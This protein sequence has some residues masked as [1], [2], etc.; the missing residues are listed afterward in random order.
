MIRE[1]LQGDIDIAMQAI[2]ACGLFTSE[3][4]PFL[5]EQ[6]ERTVSGM[7]EREE[8]WLADFLDDGSARGVC[9]CVEEPLTDRVWN[10][11]F[12][13]VIPDQ[14]HAGVGSALLEQ[15]EARL[16]ASAQRMLV[17]ETTNGPGFENAQSF[18]RKHGYS[19]EGTLRDFYA[20]GAHK[21]AFRKLLSPSQGG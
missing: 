3:E 21:I 17:I 2:K 10:L 4:I 9:F 16:R 20:D 6:L 15:V 1:V 19:E 5:R 8:F 11:L 14:Q 7:A 12:I 18:Y 13:G